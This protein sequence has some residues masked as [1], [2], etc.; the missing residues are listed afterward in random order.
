MANALKKQTGQ[1]YNEWF[2]KQVEAGLKEADNPAN[3]T[4]LENAMVEVSRDLE[5]HIN[6]NSKKTA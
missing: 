2:T 1:S 6:K 5:C 4:S 3:L